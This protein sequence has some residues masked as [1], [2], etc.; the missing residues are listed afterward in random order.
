MRPPT[1]TMNTQKQSWAASPNLFTAFAANDFPGRSTFKEA[2]DY[3]VN[4]RRSQLQ[5]QRSYICPDQL[6][7]KSHS[8]LTN[9][10]L[11]GLNAFSNPL[12]LGQLLPLFSNPFSSGIEQLLRAPLSQPLMFSAGNIESISLL[13][14]RDPRM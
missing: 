5:T 12:P 2:C 3:P 11:L 7:A 10:S 9:R 13:D 8:R 6:M 4:S 1:F 14:R